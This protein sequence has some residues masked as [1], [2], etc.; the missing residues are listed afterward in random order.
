MR[1][2]S[3]LTN[4]EVDYLIL[5]KLGHDAFI[6]EHDTVILHQRA[7]LSWSEEAIKFCGILGGRSA[8]IIHH[9][10][11]N[12]VWD[13]DVCV[14]TYKDSNFSDNDH[15]VAAMKAF[16]IGEYGDKISPELLK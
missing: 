7:R 12:L 4:N 13:G 11:I 14:A 2:V 10:K 1:S 3:S 15:T 16:V 8:E 9:G 6:R 5:K